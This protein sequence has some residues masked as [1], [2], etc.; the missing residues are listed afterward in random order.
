MLICQYCFQT[1]IACQHCGGNGVKPDFSLPVIKLPRPISDFATATVPLHASSVPDLIK[2]ALRSTMQYLF[3]EEFESSEAADTGSMTH[4]GVADWHRNKDIANAVEEMRKSQERYPQANLSEAAQLFLNY[5]QDPRNQEAE[6][7]VVEH[8]SSI[9]F[10]P[11][12]S[13]ET[14]KAIV[15]VGTIDQIR[16][17]S[18]QWFIWD[19]KTSKRTGEDQ[20]N[21][22][23]YQLA[24]YAIM[25]SNEFNRPVGLGG[26]LCP[27]HYRIGDNSKAIWKYPHRFNDIGPLINGIRFAVAAVRNGLVHPSPGEHCRYCPQQSTSQC[28]PL[29]RS[30][31]DENHRIRGTAPATASLTTMAQGE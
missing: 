18:G 29:L 3:T 1:N 8:K 17:V 10:T 23:I 20:L 7:T 11:A 21:M 14:K 15:I 26:L 31:C 19:L 25:A 30:I 28:I 12:S 2:C 5:T 22:Y 6:V 27:R 24:A 16:V 4:V 13:D 9:I